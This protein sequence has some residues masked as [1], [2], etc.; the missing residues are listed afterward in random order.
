MITL[1]PPPPR[2]H[3]G[4]NDDEWLWLLTY[5]DMITLL[6]AFFILMASI[7]KVD[8]AKFEE[9]KASMAKNIGKREAETP[10]ETL[11]NDVQDIVN[12]LHL[13]E[14][15]GVGTDSDGVFLDVASS[16]FFNSGSAAI[17]AEAKPVLDEIATTINAPRYAA[18][19]LEVQGHTDDSPINTPTFPSNWELS[20]ARATG[21]VRT[22][23]EDGIAPN[24]LRAV[25]YADV[26]PK[27]PNRD[28]NGNPLAANRE[29]NRRITVRIYP[30]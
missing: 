1:R 9:V 25:G 18:F 13:T 30:R 11:K 10:L 15:S 29:I 17:R 3:K 26:M 12:R 19:Q 28:P 8:T 14:T 6:M 5:A 2:S 7:S 4:S 27:V 23:I 16:S 20:A 22:F 24:R 21:V